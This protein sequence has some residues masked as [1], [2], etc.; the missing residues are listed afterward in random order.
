M[1]NT[2]QRKV[3]KALSMKT[4]SARKNPLIALRLGAF[5]LAVVLVGCKKKAAAAAGQVMNS[6]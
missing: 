6:P 5:A 3:A 1:T 2:Y 4:R